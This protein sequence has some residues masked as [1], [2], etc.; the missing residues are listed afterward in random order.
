MG[1]GDFV[2]CPA[3]GKNTAVPESYKMMRD[4]HRLSASDAAQLDALCKDISRP[5]ATWERVFVWV[6]YGVGILTC[7]VLAI[8]ALV[9]A[10][11]GA[12]AGDKLGA[13]DT[14]TKI[15]AG[16]GIVI[17]GIVSVPFVGEWL[18]ASLLTNADAASEAVA[19]AQM[20]WASDLTVAGILYFFGIVPIALAWR[21][22][23]NISSLEALQSQLSAAPAATPGGTSSCRRCGAPLEV[24][25]GALA[26]RCNYCG[27]DN[28]LS[29][30]DA[31]AKKKKEDATAIDDQVQAAVLAHDRTKRADRSTMWL[32]LATGPLLAPVLCGAGWLMHV[33]LSA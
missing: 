31:Y 9:G 25:P 14:V 21:T 17:C 5:P 7:L 15:A 2:T 1:D 29:V 23:Q 19:T 16:I 20:N 13:G 3:C 27:A 11:G 24:R 12:I 6:G 32:L 30:P 28:L 18:I 26:T 22:S 33:I 8:G 10:I 4:A